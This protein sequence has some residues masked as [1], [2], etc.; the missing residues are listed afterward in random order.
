MKKI[1]KIISILLMTAMLM[2]MLGVCS[3]AANS[4]YTIKDGTL[5]SYTGE[6]G[7]LVIPSDLGIKR[8]DMYAF[9]NCEELTSVTIPAKVESIDPRAF[10]W[11]RKLASITVADGNA[12]YISVG[13]VL[14]TKDKTK[15]V[16][17]PCGKAGS[18]VI[19]SGV[20]EIMMMAFAGCEGLSGITIP[21]GVKL[22]DANAFSGSTGL[23]SVTIPASVTSIGPQAFGTC[24]SLTGISVASGNANYASADGV[25]FNKGMTTLICCPGGKIGSYKVSSSVR[26]IGSSAFQGCEKL[27]AITI[28]L[29]ITKIENFAFA[30][31]LALT[32]IIISSTVTV[33]GDSA[34]SGCSNLTVYGAASSTAETYAKANS[35][36][37]SAL[38]VTATA[39]SSPVLVNGSNVKFEAYNIAGN[40]YFKLRD[41]AK[42]ISGT[43]RQFEVGYDS[44]KNA[45]TLTTGKTYTSVGG[46]LTVSSKTASVTAQISTASLYLNGTEISVKAYN[47]NGN[48]YFKLRDV[49]E[50]ID[51]GVGFDTKTN[52]ISIDT[53][54]GYVFQ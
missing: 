49:A 43:D 26:T 38:N 7:N 32:R 41:L 15:L 39:T 37:F 47:I 18:Y 17:Y 51:F 11:C 31:C 25:L 44:G 23:T 5:T 42:A 29:G 45:I 54:A 36:T 52:T 34:F 30:N 8:I 4:D 22:I 14:F 28:P 3:Y 53:K 6:G 2:A 16:C 21:E 46:E 50:A 40:N 35:L 9:T 12:N 1:K 24:D 33:I 20:T 48:N 10:A 19:P 27:F 13:G